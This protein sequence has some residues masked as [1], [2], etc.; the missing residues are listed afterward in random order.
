MRQKNED[1][2]RLVGDDGRSILHDS[3]IAYKTL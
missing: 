2:I 1:I 3:K